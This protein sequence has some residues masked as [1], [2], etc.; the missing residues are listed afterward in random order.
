MSTNI[1][2]NDNCGS[3]VEIISDENTANN[4]CGQTITRIWTSTDA[5]G[6]LA[7]ATQIITLTDTEAP[8]LAGVPTDTTVECN[9]IP[10]PANVTATDNCADNIEVNFNEEITDGNCEDSYTITRTWT[11]MD[12]CGNVMV[13]T[14]VINVEDT[15]AP[16]ILSMPADITVNESAGEAIPEPATV[17][18]N[19]NCD[20][21]PSIEVETTQL[22][23]A[24]GYMLTYTYI[25]IDNC[26]NMSTMVQIITVLTGFEMTIVPQNMMYCGPTTMELTATPNNA[27]YTYEWSANN[28]TF[29]EATNNTTDF[30][31]NEAGVYNIEVIATNASGATSTATTTVTIMEGIAAEASSN[32]PICTDNT[33]TLF[34]PNGADSYAWTGPNNF[35]SSLQN[36]VIQDAEPAMAGDYVLT[37]TSNGCEDVDT[38]TVVIETELALNIQGQLLYCEGDT[39]ELVA[40][41]G[42]AF[43]WTGPGFNSDEEMAIR[44]DLVLAN[45]GI[46][47]LYANTEAGCEAT[48]EVEVI[49]KRKPT[50]TVF[51]NGPICIGNPIELFAEGGVDYYWTG[52]NGFSTDEQNP[53]VT[54]DQSP[55]EPGVYTYELEVVSEDGCSDITTLEVELQPAMDVTTSDDLVV[56]EGETIELFATG[57]IDYLWQG[58]AGF[59]TLGENATRENATAD[60]AGEY[61]VSITNEFGCEQ[62]ATI[63]VSIENVPAFTVE[64]TAETCEEGGAITLST[65]GDNSNLTFDW[66]HLPGTDNPMNINDLAA[67]EYSV[68]VSN[69][70]D[71]SF[72]LENI[73]VENDCNCV[74]PEITASDATDAS[75]DEANGTASISTLDNEDSYEYTWSPDLGTPNA[76]GNARTNLPAGAYEIT[77]AVAGIADCETVISIV[78]GTQD[79]PEVTDISTTPAT[80]ELTNGTAA[81]SPTTYTYNWLT[82]GTTAAQRNDLAAGI[83]EVEVIDQSLP[84][85]P[86]YIQ[87]EIGEE[88]NF[89][90]TANV[91]AQPSCEQENGAVE[92]S[93]TGDFEVIWEDG[94]TLTN[95]NDLA[96][97]TYNI[98]VTNTT[99]GCADT[100]AI[101]LEAIPMGEAQVAVEVATVNCFGNADATV[102]YNVTYDTDFI[103]PATERIIDAAG[104]EVQNGQLAPGLH[105]IEVLDANGCIA[106]EGCFEVLEPAELQAV[107]ETNAATCIESGAIF[108][109][110]SGGTTPMAF[111]WNDLTGNTQ[112]Q[113]REDVEAGIYSVTISDAKGCAITLENIEVADEC[114]GCIPPVITNIDITDAD[115]GQANGVATINVEGN[116][117][118]FTY[119]LS[120]IHI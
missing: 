88:N 66:A 32:T 33:L 18:V 102:I 5:C 30:T 28:G 15:T 92:I 112:P 13:A 79:G 52:P 110:I 4:D 73:I 65:I 80:C 67:G 95:R 26:G 98:T 109:T 104:N 94:N 48:V 72:I 100:L 59:L 119:T 69:A 38:T 93:T 86:T 19:D 58:P 42:E 63:N 77:V 10:A 90:A 20:N 3:D 82:D 120:L 68:I 115:C 23:T 51:Y 118:D 76:V 12:A 61:I 70:G 14:Q 27:D 1:A 46:Y 57:G 50:P 78:I 103:N 34:A 11:A 39:M 44:P 101:T 71:C 31:M 85:C 97:D 8:I 2:A 106:G 43:S 108:V 87:V 7:Q 111:E 40:T 113:S 45:G 56:C 24:D 21:E 114:D 62:S 117:N 25:A 17:M 22:P 96:A 75:C 60:M 49:V 107:T 37:M 81:L 36:P 35:Q 41:A 74:I 99:S 47:T 54:A 83:Y 16:E 64:T 116:S 53:I 91:T 9:A 84:N 55:T 29:S 6:N 89:E 105:C